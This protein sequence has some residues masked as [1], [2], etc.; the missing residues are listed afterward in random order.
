M[1]EAIVACC[2]CLLFHQYPVMYCLVWHRAYDRE[3][4]EIFVQYADACM[5][6][7]SRMRR[8]SAGGSITLL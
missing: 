3:D 1:D 6:G 4:L 2:H 7:N 8:Q 5:Q